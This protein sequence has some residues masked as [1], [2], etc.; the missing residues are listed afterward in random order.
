MLHRVNTMPSYD[1]FR[2]VT[3]MVCGIML[4]M[5]KQQI[6]AIFT[7]DYR[8]PWMIAQEADEKAELE[9]RVTEGTEL[10]W[11]RAA[12]ESRRRISDKYPTKKRVQDGII[13]LTKTP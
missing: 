7:D 4:G 3:K 9:R 8:P 12:E 6:D 1:H 11:R 5:N 2:Q 10:A 13:D